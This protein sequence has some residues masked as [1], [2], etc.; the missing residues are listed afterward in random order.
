MRLAFT[1][2]KLR[3]ELH[4]QLLNRTCLLCT[5]SGAVTARLAHQISPVRKCVAVD[6]VVAEPP[7]TS[8]SGSQICGDRA[9]QFHPIVIPIQPIHLCDLRV[10]Q[11][12]WRSQGVHQFLL[13]VS[14]FHPHWDISS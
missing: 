8:N 12:F 10:R 9:V 14:A 1:E 6:G 7:S 4:H 3:L 13:L 2:R 11:N 5:T